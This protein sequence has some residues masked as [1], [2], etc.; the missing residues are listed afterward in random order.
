MH[1]QK[2]KKKIYI[3]IYI[4]TQGYGTKPNNKNKKERMRP[5]CQHGGLELFKSTK[6]I[7]TFRNIKGINHACYW[8]F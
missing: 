7:D 1:S 5:Y 3:Y 4:Y 8:A 2:N 6:V